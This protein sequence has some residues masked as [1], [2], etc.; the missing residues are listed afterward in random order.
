[1]PVIEGNLIRHMRARRAL[2]ALL[3]LP[4]LAL[5]Q[6]KRAAEAPPASGRYLIEALPA[7]VD[8]VVHTA[9]LPALLAAAETDG[10][11]AAKTWRQAFRAQLERWGERTGAPEIL[12]EGAERLLAAADGEALV[13]S[14]PLPAVEGPPRATILAFRTSHKAKAVEEAFAQVYEGGLIADYPGAPS[15][16]QVGGRPVQAISGVGSRIYVLIQDGLVA[17]SDHPLALGLL[18]R[19]LERMGEPQPAGEMLLEVRHGRGEAAWSGWFYGQR[20]SVSW[21]S[22]APGAVTAPLAYGIEPLV[23]VALPRAGDAP[24]LPAPAPSW[25][26][27]LPSGE[28][29]RLVAI[30]REG[31]FH[32]MGDDD[33][34]EVGVSE[35]GV[36]ATKVDGVWIAASGEI[37]LDTKREKPASPPRIAGGAARLGWLRGWASGRLRIPLPQVDRDL[38]LAPLTAAATASEGQES[39]LTWKAPERPGELRGPRW[40][41][42]ATMLALRTLADIAAKRAPEFAREG[43][44][45]VETGPEPPP[46]RTDG[47]TLPPPTAPRDGE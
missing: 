33:S 11:G 21:R 35:K 6:G 34:V 16:E 44:R 9:N 29:D 27:D 17:A 2:T 39:F 47:A 43:A 30:T 5:A 4:A 20:E 22:G 3:L 26:A 46:L 13:A 19:G 8:L 31:R 45:E 41:G 25:L 28:G 23:A 38:L 1:L 12:V 37:T 7:R 24:L 40:H 14:L 42:P 15:A 32:V 18:F 36:H 10:L